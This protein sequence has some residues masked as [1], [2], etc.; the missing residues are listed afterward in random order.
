MDNSQ[1]S[2]LTNAGRKVFVSYAREDKGHIEKLAK[3]LE[4][5]GHTVWWD[6]LLLAGEH[7]R[8]KIIKQ[9]DDADKVIVVWSSHSVKSP[10]VIDEAQR[11]NNSNKLIPVV[12]DVAE[13]PMGFGH[14]YAVTAKTL[15]SEYP[16]ILAGVE[17]WLPPTRDQDRRHINKLRQLLAGTTALLIMFV[18]G[19]GAYYAYTKIVPTNLTVG[20]NPAM[21]YR[22]YNSERLGITMVYPKSR[23]M[24]DTTQG[25][26]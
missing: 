16:A 11:A 23:L 3:F 15:E 24:V 22:V 21:D 19:Y 17:N 25:Q 13:P 14:I 9:I 26:S 2:N 7:Y 4:R 5:N 18:A 1:V 6:H 10:F 8:E 20:L 12:M